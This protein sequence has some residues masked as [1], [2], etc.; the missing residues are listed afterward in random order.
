[1]PGAESVVLTVLVEREI[2]GPDDRRRIRTAQQLV[3]ALEDD[4]TMR[5]DRA[6]T[7]NHTAEADDIRRVTAFLRHRF[8]RPDTELDLRARARLKETVIEERGAMFGIANQETARCL[9]RNHAPGRI[10]LD[11]RAELSAA[12]VIEAPELKRIAECLAPIFRRMAHDVERADETVVVEREILNVAR[13]FN[14]MPRRV[15]DLMPTTIAVLDETR[16]KEHIPLTDVHTPARVKKEASLTV[17]CIRLFLRRHV[18]GS[19][20]TKLK[21]RISCDVKV[22]LRIKPDRAVIRNRPAA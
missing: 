7:G 11:A 16:L 13:A 14:R 20:I 17:K 15:D 6:V 22:A 8:G 2:A 12:R 18:I 5:L 4:G 3:G 9:H 19:R 1:M 10:V 21:M